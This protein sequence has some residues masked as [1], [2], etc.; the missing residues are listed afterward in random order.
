MTNE[1]RKT[2]ARLTTAA[3][4]LL[5]VLVCL[6]VTPIRE[7]MGRIVAMFSTGDFTELQAFI[8]SYGGY[9]AA[10]SFGLM[11]FQSLAAPLPAFLLAFANAAMF[12]FWRGFLLTYVS[13]LVAAAICF[14]IGRVFGRDAVI[15]LVSRTGLTG[16]EEF[17]ERHGRLSVL[18]ARLLPFISF[19][20]VSYAAGLTSMGIWPFLLATAIGELP[21]TVVYCYVGGLLTGGA[22]LLIDALLILFAL[23]GLII[24]GRQLYKEHESKQ[25]SAGEVERPKR[26]LILFT[27]VPEPGKTKTRLMPAYSPEECA[28]IHTGFLRQIAREANDIYA[29]LRVYATPSKED[30]AFRAL[31]PNRA[32]FFLQEGDDLGARMERALTETLE[33]GYDAAVLVG[34]DL[35]ELTSED[36]RCAFRIL[37]QRDVA[38][39]PTGDGG[40]WLIG[41][42]VPSHAPFEPKEYG[43]GSVFEKTLSGIRSEGLTIGLVRTL[44]D[45]DTPEDL[46]AFRERTRRKRA[47]KLP[48][49]KTELPENAR[50]SVIIPSYN[51][52][53]TLP[54]LLPQL[55]P[56][57]E[58]TSPWNGRIE[59]LFADGGSSDGTVDYLKN[60]KWP[61]LQTGKGR[62]NQMNEAV[63]QTSGEVL[64][65]LHC[66]SEVP[67]DFPEEIFEVLKTREAGCF[68][69]DYRTG[70][71]GMKVNAVYANRVRLSR[72]HIMFGDQGMFL[73]RNLFYRAGMFPPLPLMED[74]QLSFTLRDMGVLPGLTK[75]RIITSPR[76]HPDRNFFKQ[77]I[78]LHQYP[79]LRKL[80]RTGAPMDEIVRRYRDIR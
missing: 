37:E 13:S 7:T 24:L 20:I 3:L 42:S 41:L 4:L 8:A 74:L 64:F 56:F 76:R 22:R 45:V 78:S 5:L 43:T 19:D 17:F 52:M 36:F 33:S 29:D 38:L 67:S 15:R 58:E 60:Q 49:P 66:D 1:K 54:T 30:P 27:R 46:D 44:D 77:M 80:Y 70:G 16:V 14:S 63:L 40:Y 25:D 59:F 61:V 51:E 47:G 12:G 73:T 71:L 57:R 21:A 72:Q 50:L 31:F 79:E 32:E 69:I 62:A 34:T 26:A 11:V 2:A 28:A 39:G 23:T 35:P 9:A 6:A 53:S 75:E 18:I 48:F 10:V 65:F 68:G 55:E